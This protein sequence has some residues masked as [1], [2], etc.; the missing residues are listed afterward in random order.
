[1]NRPR[2]WLEPFAGTASCWLRLHLGAQSRPLLAY[3]GSKRRHASTILAALD[4]H[5]GQSADAVILADAGCWGRAWLHLST[6]EGAA[7]VAGVL[8]GWMGRDPS[9]LWRELAA[10]P[11]PAAWSAEEVAS[12]SVLQGCHAGAVPIWYEPGRGW[13]QADRVGGG[14]AGRAGGERGIAPETIAARALTLHS[15]AWP[16]TGIHPGRCE[17]L[18]PEDVAA[19]LWIQGRVS[20]GVAVWP[21]ETGWQK[22]RPNGGTDRCWERGGDMPAA[23]AG[24]QEPATMA[25]RARVLHARPWPPTGVLAGR[26]EGLDIQGDLSGCVVYLDPPYVGCTGYGVN[27]GRDTVLEMADRYR[28]GGATVAISEAVGLAGELGWGWEMGI[29]EREVLTLSRRPAVSRA[30]QQDLFVGG[31]T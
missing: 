28:R 14:P 10:R 18:T 5:P 19:W 20:A 8:Q 4:L 7:A 26:C 1:M 6:P 2:L 17:A 9:E 21:G 29:A 27:T 13:L 12:W 11:V 22:C 24:I 15:R 31:A 16:A 30:T 25:A 3:M 23:G